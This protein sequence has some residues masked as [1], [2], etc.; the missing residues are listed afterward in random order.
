MDAP[1]PTPATVTLF[2]GASSDVHPQFVQAARDTGRF[3]GEKGVHVVYGGGLIGLMGEAA[4]AARAAGAP[5]TGILPAFLI[6][7]EGGAPEGTALEVTPD[8]MKRKT[9]MAEMADAFIVLP[10]GL[11]TL[12]EV[13]EMLTWTQLGL[14]RGK[15]LGFLNVDGF[16]DALFRFLAQLS[17][18]GFIPES[19]APPWYHDRTLPGLWDQLVAAR[20]A[21]PS[22]AAPAPPVGDG[23]G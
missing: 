6:G 7:R 3:L 13:F 15:P 18:Q 16:F 22:A 8:V 23:E 20:S 9:R 4:Q 17:S 12:D 11:G 1:H 10:G 2:C 19:S 14:L 21:A 5:V